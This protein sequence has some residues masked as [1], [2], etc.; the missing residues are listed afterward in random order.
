MYS[1]LDS[2]FQGPILLPKHPSPPPPPLLLKSDP[3]SSP[4]SL[5]QVA[6]RLFSSVTPRIRPQGP[7][8]L[9]P[10]L[11]RH[12]AHVPP[13]KKWFHRE[14]RMRGEGGYDSEEATPARV[15]PLRLKI[16]NG[17]GCEI[18]TYELL[19][20]LFTGPANAMDYEYGVVVTVNGG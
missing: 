5:P 1:V 2:F 9:P 12:R 4:S 15:D 16:Q 18:P 20:G 13:P 17:A 7:Q 6:P 8:N 10:P 19:F 3:T 11:Y 14:I